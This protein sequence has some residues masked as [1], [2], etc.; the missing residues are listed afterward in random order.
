MTNEV[1]L[2]VAASEVLALL[3]ALAL[4]EQDEAKKLILAY[5]SNQ[6]WRALNQAETIPSPPPSPEVH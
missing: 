5:H 4:D 2:Q 6:L 3:D 1:K